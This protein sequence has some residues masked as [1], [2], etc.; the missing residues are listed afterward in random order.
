[1]PRRYARV[2]DEAAP[3]IPPLGALMDLPV[4]GTPFRSAVRNELFAARCT[5]SEKVARDPSCKELVLGPGTWLNAAAV[6]AF[7]AK[8]PHSGGRLVLR[9]P[10][11]AR[12]AGGPVER[13]IDAAIVPAGTAVDAAARAALP[14]VVLDAD[15]KDFGVAKG[16]EALD[17]PAPRLVACDV[18]SWADLLWVS[19]FSM[20][21][22]VR[23]FSAAKGLWLV[24]SGALKSLSL[25]KWLI[26]GEMVQRGKGCDVHPSAVVE[27]SVLGDG[28]KIGPGAVVR[29]SILQRGAEVEE[30]ALVVGSVVGANARV[31]RQSMFKFSVLSNSASCGGTVQLSFF[32]EG[33]TL[34]GGSYTIDRN[35]DGSPVRVTLADGSLADA[36]PVL[37]VALGPRSAI[38][39]G[40]W[41]GAGRAIPADVT[42]IRSPYDTVL[43]FGKDVPPGVYAVVDGSLAVVP[44]GSPRTKDAES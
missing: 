17:V 36:G 44:T 1:M 38:G 6:T 19:L 22:Q 31:Q 25:D 30:L 28:V 41:I 10:G 40:V 13:A 24:A 12:L 35:L 23:N 34:R 29:G 8:A 9:A 42:V 26:A 5:V 7:F 3:L 18:R 11:W 33:A 37:G 21:A 16:P 32:G 4:M 2:A 20:T 15:E 39:S 27:A 43:R 14:P